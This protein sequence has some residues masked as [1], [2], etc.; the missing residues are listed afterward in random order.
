MQFNLQ[1]RQGGS[2]KASLV[3]VNDKTRLVL[4]PRNVGK[5][6]MRQLRTKKHFLEHVTGNPV[7]KGKK[8][9]CDLELS[10]DPEERNEMLEKTLVSITR[11]LNNLLLTAEICRSSNRDNKR[12]SRSHHNKPRPKDMSFAV[13]SSSAKP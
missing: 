6:I 8:V 9:I 13:F 7:F 5:A 4:H 2:V 12:R 11:T 10:D 3:E 1:L